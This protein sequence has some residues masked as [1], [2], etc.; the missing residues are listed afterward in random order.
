LEKREKKQKEVQQIIM[1]NACAS[2]ATVVDNDGVNTNG[3]QDN[4]ENNIVSV[5]GS[6]QTT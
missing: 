1:G 2:T 3:P 5:E 6:E 4:L